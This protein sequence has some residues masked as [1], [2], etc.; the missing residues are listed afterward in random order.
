MFPLR[1][2]VDFSYRWTK[3]VKKLLEGS[4]QYS[5]KPTSGHCPVSL[6]SILISY[7]PRLTLASGSF[8]SGIFTTKILTFIFHLFDECTAH[9]ILL[10]LFTLMIFGGDTDLKALH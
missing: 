7:H 9:V 1:I 3:L 8:P 10:A 2:H 5:Q 4:L 6:R